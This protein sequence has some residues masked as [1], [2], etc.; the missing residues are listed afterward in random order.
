MHAP[1]G[2]RF[3]GGIVAGS[4]NVYVLTLAPALTVLV[5]RM[6]I[7]ARANFNLG[8]RDALTPFESRLLHSMLVEQRR[9]GVVPNPSARGGRQEQ[10]AADLGDEPGRTLAHVEGLD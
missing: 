6:M 8:H 3:R 10:Y 1:V 9:D 7:W 4:S 2:E 5:D